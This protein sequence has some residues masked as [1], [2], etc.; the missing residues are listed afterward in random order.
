MVV[1]AVIQHHGLSVVAMAAMVVTE[2]MVDME[3]PLLNPALAPWHTIS[4][5]GFGLEL[6][7][8]ASRTF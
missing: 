5:R 1:I 6:S 2:V 8:S 7:T 3:V 4:T